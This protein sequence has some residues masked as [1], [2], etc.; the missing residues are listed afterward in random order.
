MIPSTNL[1][2]DKK[3]FEWGL[4]RYDEKMLQIKLT[5]YY[6]EYISMDEKPDVLKIVFDN[7]QVTMYPADGD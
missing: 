3:T 4:I 6:P 1:H 2:Q 7:T 5:F